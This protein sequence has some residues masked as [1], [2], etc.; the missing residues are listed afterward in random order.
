MNIEGDGSVF[1]E[2]LGALIWIVESDDFG[3]GW[4]E[5]KSVGIEFTVDFSVGGLR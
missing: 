4:M 2:L 3:A 1:G 5:A